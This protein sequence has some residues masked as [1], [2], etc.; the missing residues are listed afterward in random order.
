MSGR[1][2]IKGFSILEI[3]L[4]LAVAGMLLTA[5][6]Y[7]IFVFS[8]IWLNHSESDYFPHHV[9]G[10][11]VFLNNVVAL[12][13]TLDEE[14]KL[15]IAWGRPPGYSELDKPLL[16]FELRDCPPLFVWSDR[17]LA[18]VTCH[19][20]FRQREGLAILWHSRLQETEDIADVQNTLL[21]PFVTEVM[22]CYYDPEDDSWKKSDEPEKDKDD[23]YLV[24]QFIELKFEH[25]DE[26][27][28]AVI[29]LPPQN[30]QAPLY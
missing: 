17:P 25:E 21:S 7:Q 22:Y 30:R 5:A 9:D 13:E 27:R 4:A 8:N 19:L 24:P 11:T 12:A 16:T 15:P 6:T 2:S 28:T 3:L 29:Y 14:Q 1:K 18:A 26:T 20:V 10:I 23:A